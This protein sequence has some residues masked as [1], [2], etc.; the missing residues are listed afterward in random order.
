[1]KLLERNQRA[2]MVRLM[3]E[4]ADDLWYLRT[5]IDRGDLC[6]GDSEYK[7]NLGSGRDGKSQVVKKKV[8]V[9]INAE[10]TEFG[11]GTLRIQG[12]VTG[13]SEEV[14]RGSYNSL[15]ITEG[16]K[17]TIVKERWLTYQEEKLE[18]AL[19][20]TVNTLLLLFDRESAIFTL[21]KPHGYETAL[22]L[23]GDVPKKGVDEAKQH[24][25]Y[26]DIVRHLLEFAERGIQ[27]IIAGSPSFWKEYLEKELTPE[28]RSKVIFTSVSAV[29]ET[30]INEVLLRPELQQALKQQ[31]AS[32]ELHL[33]GKILEALGKDRLI[34][35][36][37]DLEEALA[38]GNIAELTVTEAA[39]EKAKEQGTFEELEG[40]MRKASDVKAQVHLLSTE[41]AMQKVDGLGGI[42][43]IRRW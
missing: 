33:L 38:A 3:A 32:R 25:F 28:L 42:V 19:Q 27:H 9:T 22:T 2:G 37:A 26:R 7:Y 31:R 36:K 23:K 8:F 30:A 13:G 10:K 14:P 29:D 41:G 21:L 12:K 18:E 34:Y 20:G 4:T 16:S 15:D 35:G 1:M 17:L 24:T 11:S 40:M 5:I 43:G 6:S 39:M